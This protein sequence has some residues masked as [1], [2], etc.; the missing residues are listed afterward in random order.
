MHCLSSLNYLSYLLSYIQCR[1][2]SELGVCASGCLLGSRRSPMY[3]TVI[4]QTAGWKKIWQWL[5]HKLAEFAQRSNTSS[6]TLKNITNFINWAF[7]ETTSGSTAQES[8][9]CLWNL[10]VH[11]RLHKSSPQVPFL[12]QWTQF[13]PRFCFSKIYFNIIFPYN[14]DLPSVLFLFLNLIQTYSRLRIYK[15]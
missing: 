11:C 14:L 10:E 13:T 8:P 12:S 3:V 9:K 15:T 5:L 2:C 6:K 1:E 4:F 7:W